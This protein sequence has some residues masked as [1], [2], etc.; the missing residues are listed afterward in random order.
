MTAPE[1]PRRSRG[2]SAE[3]ERRIRYL[4]RRIEEIEGQQRDATPE[5]SERAALLEA[6]EALRRLRWRE[7]Q[8]EQPPAD[9]SARVVAFIRGGGLAVLRP[10]GGRF[11]CRCGCGRIVQVEDVQRWSLAPS[12]DARR[13][14]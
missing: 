14:R 3:L 7:P 6:A 9:P 1:K 13:S 11:V 10:D 5:R 12:S 2:A 4:D 8:H